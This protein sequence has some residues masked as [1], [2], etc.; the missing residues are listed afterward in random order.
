M[1]LF[2]PHPLLRNSHCMTLAGAYWPRRFS[3]LPAGVARLFEVE[4]GTRLLAECHWQSNPRRHPTLV[5]VHG[6]EGSSRSPYMLGIAEKAFAAGFNVTRMNQRN[7]GDTEHLTPT[8]YNSG[9]SGDYAAILRELAE[10]EVLPEVF[11][12]G[13]SMGG[14]LVLKMAGELGANAPRALRGVSTVC[15]TLDLAAC[16]E[17]ISW[18][19]NFI[20]QWHFVTGLK[21][22]LRRKAKLFPREYSTGCLEGIRTIREFDNGITA[23]HCGY[24]DAADYYSRASAARVAATIGVPTLILTAEDDPIVPLATLQNPAI[25]SNPNITLEAPRYGG[26]CAFISRDR[27]AARFWAEMRVV[28]FCCQHSQLIRAD[29]SGR[30]KR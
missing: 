2:E 30:E 29:Q 7:C 5:L 21:R 16:V 3:R 24:R 12:T 14:N 17:A 4:P 20:Y 19:Q 28:E 11:F 18:P 8:L 26:H 6:L 13:Y 27:G 9:L 15:P 25:R 22:R 10:G 23:P 1:K